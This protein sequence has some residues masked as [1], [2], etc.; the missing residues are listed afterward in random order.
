MG[1]ARK[2]GRRPIPPG[3]IAHAPTAT[4][5]ASV[6]SRTVSAVLSVGG[7]SPGNCASRS[8]NATPFAP[9]ACAAE[10][11]AVFASGQLSAMPPGGDHVAVLG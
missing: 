3:A 9:P 4:S 5:T 2:R 7:A 11:T 6:C 1:T 8:A 10:K